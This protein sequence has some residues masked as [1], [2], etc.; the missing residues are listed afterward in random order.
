MCEFP[1]RSSAFLLSPLLFP[2]SVTIRVRES[3]PPKRR[4]LNFFGP[5]VSFPPPFLGECVSAQQVTS[6]SSLMLDDQLQKSLPFGSSH[7]CWKFCTDWTFSFIQ[8]F[9]PPSPGLAILRTRSCSTLQFRSECDVFFLP[10]VKFASLF[11]VLSHPPRCALEFILFFPPGSQLLR[12]QIFAAGRR[13]CHFFVL[14]SV[15]P[16]GRSSSCSY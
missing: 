9:S 2:Q 1:S 8:L 16:W 10:D 4:D 3:P 6:L 11:W 12:F 5:S 13:R 7:T 15:G 14:G